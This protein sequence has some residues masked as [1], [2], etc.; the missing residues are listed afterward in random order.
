MEAEIAVVHLQAEE[1]QGLLTTTRSEEE[2]RKD[3]PLD[4]S[5]GARPY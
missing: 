1:Q 4:S 2:A 3:S 5:E